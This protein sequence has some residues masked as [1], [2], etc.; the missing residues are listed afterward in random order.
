M[1]GANALAYLRLH[2]CRCR[3]IKLRESEKPSSLLD[4]SSDSK[5][6]CFFNV[7]E[8]R[9][10]GG[11]KLREKRREKPGKSRKNAEKGGKNV[12]KMWGNIRK[13][14]EKDRKKAGQRRE[15]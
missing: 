11:K 9:K 5:R 12:G 2:R 6:K 14:L 8:W 10:N 4:W 13:M 1:R 3:R 15:K 7:D